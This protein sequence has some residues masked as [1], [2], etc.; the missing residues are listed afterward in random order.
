MRCRAKVLQRAE[1]DFP[2]HGSEAKKLLIVKYRMISLHQ[3]FPIARLAGNISNLVSQSKT[4]IAFYVRIATIVIS[5]QTIG[6]EWL[7]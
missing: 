1:R 3:L 5:P 4:I 6:L 7:R 2:M